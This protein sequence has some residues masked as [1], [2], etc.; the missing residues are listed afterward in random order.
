MRATLAV[1]GAADVRQVC[2]AWGGFATVP[3][4]E[5]SPSLTKRELGLVVALGAALALLMHWPLPL[6]MTRDV[7]RDIGDPL[8]QAWQVAWGGHALLH[9][10]LD[11]FQA[12]TYWPMK[13]SLAVSEALAG[14]APA[15]TAGSG[16]TAAVLR[17]DLL[18]LFA[19]ALCFVGAWLLA[20]ELGAGRAGA[21]VA[22][23]AF[24]YAP[25]RLE[26]DGHLHVLS[27]G[28]I[29]LSLFLLARGYRNER[30]GLVL[31]GWLVASWQLSLGFTLGLQ[32]AYLLLA[33]GAGAVFLLLRRGGRPTRAVTAVTAAGVVAFALTGLL[34]AR[35][36]LRVVDDHP[37]AKRTSAQV[38][39]L[40]GPLV[41]YIAAPEQNL[42][43][44]KATKPIRD[45]LASVPEQTLFPGLTIFALAVTGLFWSV[46]RRSLRLGLGIAAAAF[47]I[48]ALGFDDQHAH[49]Y[50]YRL[51]YDVAPG[52]SGI[53]VPGRLTTLTSLALALLAA[54]GA[55]RIADRVRIGGA[56]PA[57]AVALVALICIEGS[58]FDFRSG[59]GLAGPS[60][61]AVPKPPAE[62]TSPPPPQLHLPI[63]IP[64]NRRYVLWSTDGFPEIVNGRGSFDPAFFERLTERVTG[65]PDRASV[66]LLR[67]M[68][69]R[70]VVLHEALAPGTPWAGAAARPLRGLPLRRVGGRGLVIYLLESGPVGETAARAGRTRN[71]T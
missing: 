38:A 44:G 50:P 7:P 18:F 10:P 60:H 49:L 1:R 11:Y 23:A 33:L 57:L 6:H 30:P 14:Y 26:Q 28:G 68:G 62:A 41:S 52:W 69:V 3:R 71:R 12:N 45:D 39:E 63:T 31:A 66:E 17:Y 65:F 15:G 35:P 27:S 40:S 51:L 37:E 21:A 16:V 70:S 25:W 67:A 61:P 20:R 55:Q 19:Y 56:A 46:Y 29:P 48:L 32:L 58:G 59:G 22:G 24:A 42:V 9:Q 54:G 64:A 2:L 43:W 5:R 53:R 36:Y 34:L 8:V 4:I 13:D 47:A